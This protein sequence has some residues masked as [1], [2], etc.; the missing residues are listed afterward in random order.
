MKKMLAK[1]SMDW[2][3]VFNYIDKDPPQ[4]Y[5]LSLYQRKEGK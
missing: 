1:K 2:V 5:V 3:R 4:T